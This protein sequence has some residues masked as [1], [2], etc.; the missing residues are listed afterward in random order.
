[1][2]SFVDL[3]TNSDIQNSAVSKPGGLGSALA[4][5][6][7]TVEMAAEQ[8]QKYGNVGTIADIFD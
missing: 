3:P 6:A 4:D 8:E 7:K 1:M 2:S 5:E